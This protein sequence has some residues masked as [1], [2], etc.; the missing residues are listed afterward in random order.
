[1]AVALLFPP[2]VVKSIFKLNSHPDEFV[3]PNEVEVLFLLAKQKTDTS[4]DLT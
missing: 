2:P 1:V 3:Y 4:T